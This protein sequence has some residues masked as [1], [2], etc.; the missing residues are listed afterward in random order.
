MTPSAAVIEFKQ[1]ILAADAI[2]FATPEYNYSLPG[3]LKNAIDWAHA[4][5]SKMPGKANPRPSWGFPLAASAL[6]APSTT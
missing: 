1:K 5:M 2:L 6:P 4:P 3:G